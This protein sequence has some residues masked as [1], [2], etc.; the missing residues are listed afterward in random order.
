[1]RE[2]NEEMKNINIRIGEL[3]GEIR[4]NNEKYSKELAIDINKYR[5]EMIKEYEEKLQILKDAEMI[6]LGIDYKK[7]R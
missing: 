1:M 3:M 5:E 2:L 6:L 4:I 7:Y